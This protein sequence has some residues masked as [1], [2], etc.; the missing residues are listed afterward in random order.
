MECLRHIDEEERES[1]VYQWQSHSG[2]DRI[3]VSL[4]LVWFGYFLWRWQLQV[5]AW[6]K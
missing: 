4:I 3:L 1:Y 2:G 6:E 5:L